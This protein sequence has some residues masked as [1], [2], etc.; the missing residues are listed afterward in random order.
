MAAVPSGEH[1]GEMNGRRR[2]EGDLIP[3][4]DEENQASWLM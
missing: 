2:G 4:P 1:F 3:L